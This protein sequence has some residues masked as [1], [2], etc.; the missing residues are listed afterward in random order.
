MSRFSLSRDT[1][2]HRQSKARLTEDTRL[3]TAGRKEDRIAVSTSSPRHACEGGSLPCVRQQ[4]RDVRFGG[5]QDLPSRNMLRQEGG[6]SRRRA[7]GIPTATQLATSSRS[8]RPSAPERGL[9][10]PAGPAVP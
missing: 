3:L 6:Q 10:S 4:A 9:L 5:S 7:T 1:R 8:D 2:E